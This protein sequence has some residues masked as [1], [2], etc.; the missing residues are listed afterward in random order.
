MQYRNPTRC[1]VLPFLAMFGATS[2]ASQ[3]TCGQIL[4][5][6]VRPRSVVIGSFRGERFSQLLRMKDFLELQGVEILSPAGAEVVE[7]EATFVRLVA[8]APNRS[9]GELQQEVL[10]K[11]KEQCS[12]VAV[13][14]PEGYVGR[15]TSMEMGYAHGIGLPVFTSEVERDENFNWFT[16]PLEHIFPHWPEYQRLQ[17]HF[18]PSKEEA[19]RTSVQ[20]QVFQKT[21][22]TLPRL[23]QEGD[24]YAVGVLLRGREKGLWMARRLKAP[25]QG[26]YTGVGGKLEEEETIEQCARR[27]VREEAGV[28]IEDLRFL[29][30]VR[31]R[32]QGAGPLY[33]DYLFSAIPKEIPRQLEP[34]KQAPWE[35]V[36]GRSLLEA[37]LFEPLI[38]LHRIGFWTTEKIGTADAGMP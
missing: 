16:L 10:S 17:G 18:S 11:I 34:R 37:E 4:E 27:E 21:L 24:H 32:D 28:E 33:V 8:D 23:P 14:N 3:L 22:Q 20:T 9:N 19:F 31:H 7:P 1:A 38:E 30:T 6:M 36:Q 35:L 29:M 2:S 12:F 25:G 26:K 13:C 15:A 5:G